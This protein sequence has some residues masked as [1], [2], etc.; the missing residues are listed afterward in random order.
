MTPMGFRPNDDH[1]FAR[2]ESLDS[3]KKKEGGREAAFIVQEEELCAGTVQLSSKAPSV[4]LHP[5]RR[6]ERAG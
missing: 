5:I 1:E 4:P 3:G 6:R 2:R